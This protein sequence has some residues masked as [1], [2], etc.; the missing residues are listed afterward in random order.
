MAAAPGEAERP[1]R[2]PRVALDARLVDGE[3]GGIQSVVL[4]LAH[5]L[6]SLPDGAEEYLFCVWSDH[7]KWLEPHVS[8]RARLL[9]V[10]PR[11]AALRS[12]A[13]LIEH[14]PFV[15]RLWRVV[16]PYLGERF[17]RP[18]RSNGAVEAAGA[19]LVDLLV[20]DGF[21]TDLPTVYHPY[22]LQHR[23]L[24]QYFSRSVRRTREVRYRILCERAELVAV[25]SSWVKEDLVEQLGL[26]PDK[27]AVVPLAAPISAYPDPRPE[28][29]D[30]TRAAY[31]LPEKFVFYPAHTWEHKNH[32]GLLEALARLRDERGVS[33]PLVCTGRLTDFYGTLERRVGDLGLAED[34]H[35]LG[36]VSPLELQCLYRL[37]TAMVMPTLFEAASLPLWEAF[38]AGCPAAC[39]NVTSLPEQAGD[40][41]LVFDP[42]DPD[43]IADA[44]ARLWL[45]PELRAELAAHGRER[46]SR[47]S[48]ERTARHFRAHYRRLCGSPLTEEDRAMLA[49]RES[50]G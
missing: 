28:D 40:A 42:H 35:F 36:F 32:L 11:P 20:Q 4:G 13:W 22:D 47:F 50:L 48:W 37:A 15:Q 34:A 1:T 26:S 29:L 18:P 38:L 30:R 49:G 2:A 7:R 41:A 45:D 25:E 12:R 24:P 43:S 23:H 21:L 8:G 39:S 31:D 33:V 46:V 5:G 14:A 27:I 6:S 44:V 17:F 16:A 10:G 9:D 19:D 3:H